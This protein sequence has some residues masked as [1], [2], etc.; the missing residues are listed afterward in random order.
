MKLSVVVP[1]CG[2]LNYTREC[3]NHLRAHTAEYELIVIDNG[4]PKQEFKF[5]VE[6]MQKACSVTC[7]ISHFQNMGVTQAWNEGIDKATGEFIVFLN[8]DVIVVP[9]WADRLIAHM[10]NNSDIWC[11]CPQS[12]AGV[13]APTF[14]VD[15]TNCANRKPEVAP[16][17]IGWCFMLRRSRLRSIFPDG[18]FDR[19]FKVWY[20]DTDLHE[21]LAKVGHPA[22]QANNVLI[23]H[24]E[25][26]TLRTIPEVG[27]QIAEDAKEFE[28]KWRS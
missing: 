18:H 1:V 19:R 14:S 17:F 11:I 5:L 6:A 25:S 4:S 23:H 24:F 12:T 7:V 13:M 3:F 22:M 10:Q 20:G 2:Q 15:A 8:N 28:E 21:T 27:A 26:R 16:G 9:G